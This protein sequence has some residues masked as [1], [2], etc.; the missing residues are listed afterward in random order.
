[1]KTNSV[2]P[3]FKYRERDDQ[4]QHDK[5]ARKA[6]QLFHFMSSMRIKNILNQLINAISRWEQKFNLLVMSMDE[7]MVS[8]GY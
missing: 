1:M 6:P 3:E 4:M 5:V 8:R 7:A 2:T